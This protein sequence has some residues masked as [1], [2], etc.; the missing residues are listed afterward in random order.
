MKQKRA[1]KYR[2]Y[3]T[4]EQQS[5]LA[6]TFGCCRVV[7]NWALRKKTDAYYNQQHRLYYK[8]LSEAL[9]LLKKQDGYTWLSD[10][11]SVPLQ[12]SLRHL[13]KAF[14]TF[15]EGRAGYPTFKK[16]HNRQS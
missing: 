13:D 11:S 9:T 16:R 4:P 12:Q 14:I 8:D 2:V 7:F 6:Q 1:Y 5:I 3:P 10:V 15:F